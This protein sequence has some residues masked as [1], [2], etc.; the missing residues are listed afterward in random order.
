MNKV[1]FLIGAIPPQTGGELYNYKL[2]QCLEREGFDT[3]LISLHKKLAIRISRVPVVGNLLA[4]IALAGLLYKSKGILVEDHYFTRYLFLT[5]IIK[6]LFGENRIIILVH[7]LYGYD[8]ND[9]F[10]LRKLFKGIKHR[11]R[12]SLADIIITNSQYSRHEIVSLGIKSSLVHVIPPG[13]DREKLKFIS[14]T[15]NDKPQILCVANYLPGKGL[16]YLIKAYSQINSRNFTLHL[17]GNP[18]KASNYCHRLKKMVVKYNLTEN[19]FFHNGSDKETLQKLYSHAKIFVL[20]TLKE[21][22]GIVLIEAMHYS[23]P[24]ITTKVGAIPELITDGENGL[25]C[26][27]RNSEALAEALSKL[28][29][30]PDLRK[31]MGEISHQRVANSF[32]WQQTYSNFLECL[33]NI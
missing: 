12:L 9:N 27:P 19:V 32:Y 5:N 16:I 30:N 1:W 29:E 23:L 6:R 28:I 25:L 26:P 14:Q 7:S 2:F 24:I 10:W 15:D 11:I 17:I 3:E 33:K 20:P 18:S 4:N 8:T 22:F 13:I 21:T 31:K